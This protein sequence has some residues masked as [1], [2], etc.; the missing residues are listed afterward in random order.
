M[1][2]EWLSGEQE[3]RYGR[4]VADPTPEELER[5]FFLDEAALAEVR[6]RR[7]LHNKLGW[8]V[9]W[10]TVRMLGTF[11]TDSG[12]VQVPEVVIRYAAEQLGVREWTAV[13]QYGDRPS[14]PGPA[15]S[16]SGR[17]RSTAT[18][19]AGP[20]PGPWPSR[21]CGSPGPGPDGW[22]LAAR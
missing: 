13:K 3:D 21:T 19:P 5:F 7:G 4:F 20:R 8:S 15:R 18:R 14:T 2:H 6:T 22:P 9:Q 1:P 17:C 10:G 12:P 16:P 11:L